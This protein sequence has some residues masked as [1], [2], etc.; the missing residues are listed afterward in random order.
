MIKIVQYSERTKTKQLQTSD[1]LSK[2]FPTRNMSRNELFYV[3]KI[4]NEMS[5]IPSGINNSPTWIPRTLYHK[6]L[7]IAKIHPLLL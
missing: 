6:N 7:H 4:K 1:K 2:L 5:D 3:Q